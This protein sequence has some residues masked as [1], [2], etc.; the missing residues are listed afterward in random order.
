MN[1]ISRRDF[2]HYSAMAAAS[3]AI[4]LGF[5]GCSR[6]LTES[7]SQVPT[8]NRYGDFLPD[9]YGILDLPEGFTYHAFS[10]VGERM[11]DGFLVPGAHDGMAAFPGP[12]GKT[13]LVRN[14]ELII[15][16]QEA[17]SFAHDKRLRE[18]NP[19]KIYDSGK[20]TKPGLGGTTTLVYDT[21]TATLESHYMSLMGTIRNCAGGTT[22][23]NTWISCEETVQLAKDTYEKD[24]GYN[25]EVPASPTI[26]LTTPIPLTA[27]GRF[28]HEAVTVG[29]KSGIVYQTE[30]RHDSLIYRFIPDVP[31]KLA[32][33][34]RLQAMVI[35][36][37]K[38]A[39]TRN[40]KQ[41]TNKVFPWTYDATVAVGEKMEVAWVDIQNVESPKDDLRLQGFDKGAARFARGEGMWY[42]DNTIY[43]VCT[44]GGYRKKGQVWRYIPSP[45]EGTS[46]E[47][48]QPGVL[49]LFIEPNNSNLLENADNVTV[50]PWGDLIL[51][52]DGPGTQF[53][54][55]V[56]PEGTLYRFA[57]NSRSN[58]EFAGAT[59]SLDGS[60]LFVNIQG[61][62]MT[63]AITGPWH[64]STKV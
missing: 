18:V 42:S 19:E 43:F 62:G 51:C 30:D 13:I 47:D 15:G 60:T 36:D 55:G 34:G 9:P 33:G 44:N 16:P 63:L 8:A 22:P 32:Q 14:H 59:F 54:V 31:G 10:T 38:S 21:K 41:W 50:T 2:L 4:A 5:S 64:T 57:K 3:G 45:F 53:L 35:R 20:G 40:W 27:M 6:L 48:K 28:N 52:E 1:K 37:M 17:Q 56:T 24:H 12:N 29:A 7:T 25:F 23:W 26:G 11:D 49:E 58:S 61:A 46:A 39:D